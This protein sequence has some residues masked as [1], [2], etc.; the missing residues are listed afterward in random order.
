MA[1]RSA[2][3]AVSLEAMQ[4]A[5]EYFYELRMVFVKTGVRPNGFGLPRQHSL[6]HYVLRVAIQLAHL[7]A[8]V[9]LSHW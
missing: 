4:G 6:V 8:S 5:L 3:D 2:H 1:R 9:H 7:M